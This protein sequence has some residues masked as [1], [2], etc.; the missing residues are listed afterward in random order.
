M[1]KSLALKDACFL[2]LLSIFVMAALPS[3]AQNFWAGTWETHWAT[4]SA[5]MLLSQDGSRVSGSYPLLSGQIEAAAEGKLLRGRWSEDKR[6]GSFE[7]ILAEDGQSFIGRREGVEWWTGARNQHPQ[8]QMV[9]S[10]DTPRSTLRSFLNAGNLGRDSDK[11]QWALAASLLVADANDR[12]TSP[13]D[14]L[15][16]TIEYFRL[17]DLLTIRFPDLDLFRQTDAREVVVPLPIADSL[18]SLSVVFLRNAAGGWR[19][20]LPARQAIARDREAIL[21]LLGQET[22]A[23]RQSFEALGSPRDT[24]RSFLIGVSSWDQAG[25]D[26]ALST[27]DLSKFQPVTRD[28]H[29]ELAALQLRRVLERIG[30][31]AL[32]A[33]P[34]HLVGSNVFEIFTHSA[35]S[36]VLVADGPA[37]QRKWRFSSETVERSMELLRASDK[38]P[39][40]QFRLPGTIPTTA[41]FSLRDAVSVKAPFLLKRA[42][43]MEIWQVLGSLTGLSLSV[44]L[45]MLSARLLIIFLRRPVEQEFLTPKWFRPSLVFCLTLFFASPVPIIFGVP[46]QIR[47]VTVPIIGIALVLLMTMIIWQLLK[48]YSLHF[49]RIAERSLGA[50]DDIAVSLLFALLRLSTIA[51]CG[52]GLAHFLSISTVNILAGLGIGGLAV[53]FAARETLANIFGAA[54][55]AVDRPFKRGDMISMGDVR[56]TVEHVGIRST[57]LRTIKNSEIV[58][59]NAKLADTSITNHGASDPLAPH[60]IFRLSMEADTVSLSDFV[61]ELKANFGRLSGISDADNNILIHR[62][63]GK[64]VEIKILLSAPSDSNES[65]KLLEDLALS[66]L[67]KGREAGIGLAWTPA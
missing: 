67:A 18:E 14:K 8:T 27:L 55:L 47:H 50:G 54:V 26:L 36:V 52:L 31:E 6:E 44:L 29:G 24:I 33:I 7:F 17:L 46:P 40:T 15:A 57:R 56:G 61:D 64:D 58:V 65:R 38:L 16:R 30:I 42:G 9:G 22:A 13:E 37:D 35:G 3:V 12:V 20:K 48:I 2:L 28:A 32:Q 62:I 10:S 43:R 59:P 66:A 60:A 5:R 63:D 11:D 45:G 21:A 19:I 34:N 41:F 23:Q 1:N 51:A 53:A 25:Q 39:P 49:S 4:G